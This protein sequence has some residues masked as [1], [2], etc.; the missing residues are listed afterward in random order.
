MRRDYGIW[1]QDGENCRWVSYLEPARGVLESSCTASECKHMI[2]SIPEQL[3]AIRS[4]E[5]S[6]PDEKERD[7]I[8]NLQ[9]HRVIVSPYVSGFTPIHAHV[10]DPVSRQ[11]LCSSMLARVYYI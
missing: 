10:Q 1:I 6:A 7:R 4:G 2:Y 3:V 5:G 8:G 11:I 9:S